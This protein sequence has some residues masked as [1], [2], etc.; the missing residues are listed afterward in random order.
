MV[1]ALRMESWNPKM[2]SQK[3]L[4]TT[5]KD[6][7]TFWDIETDAFIAW[8]KLQSQ[9]TQVHTNLFVWKVGLEDVTRKIN[10]T[11]NKSLDQKKGHF[12]NK[13]VNMTHF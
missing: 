8:I 2:E 3:K 11:S 7:K 4:K 5:Q 12:T 1:D 13:V 6:I 9:I 10:K